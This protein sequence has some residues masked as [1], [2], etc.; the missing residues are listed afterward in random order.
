MTYS[1]QHLLEYIRQAAKTDHPDSDDSPVLT[2]G[3]IR[4]LD[5]YIRFLETGF[6]LGLDEIRAEGD[7]YDNRHE[8]ELIDREIGKMLGGS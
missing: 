2:Y 8:M 1:S 4:K 5:K 3:E 7:S 6:K